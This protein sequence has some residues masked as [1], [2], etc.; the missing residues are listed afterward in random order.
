MFL[1]SYGC[2]LCNGHVEESLFHIFIQYPFAISTWNL[3]HIQLPVSDNPF[4]IFADFKN[5]L[6]VLFFMDII[7]IM[8]WCIWT[9]RNDLI[10][11]N[12]APDVAN[13][14]SLFRKEFA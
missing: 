5:Q 11:R 10:F 9:A 4:E 8:A 12:I 2:A 14:D 7:I 3:L 6:Q 13:V 1:Q